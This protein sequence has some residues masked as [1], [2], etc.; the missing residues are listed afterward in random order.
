MPPKVSVYLL[1]WMNKTTS[2]EC[3][4]VVGNGISAS[5]KNTFVQVV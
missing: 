2:M 3:I 4:S 5:F 1:F